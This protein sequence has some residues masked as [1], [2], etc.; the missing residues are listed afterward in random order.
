M[1]S[2]EDQKS[3]LLKT[4]Q[5]AADNLEFET[6]IMIRDELERLESRMKKN[7]TKRRRK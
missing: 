5:N 2:M 1:M 7:K 4:M 3:F 6:A